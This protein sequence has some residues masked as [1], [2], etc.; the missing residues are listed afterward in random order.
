MV[1]I[2]M[3]IGSY[4]ELEFDK[5]KELFRDIPNNNIIRL[6]TCRAAIYHAVRCYNVKKVWIANYQ[7]IGMR[8]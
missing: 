7:C 5:G 4:F 6:N 8:K 1:G 2:K 3:D